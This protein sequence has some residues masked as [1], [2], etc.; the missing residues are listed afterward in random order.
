MCHKIHILVICLALFLTTNSLSLNNPTHDAASISPI[1]LYPNASNQASAPVNPAPAIPTSI[2]TVQPVSPIANNQP[3]AP[4][5]TGSVAPSSASIAPSFFYPQAASAPVNNAQLNSHPSV[6]A[7]AQQ[8]PVNPPSVAPQA[9]AS[10]LPSFFYPNVS[11]PQ[12]QPAPQIPVAQPQVPVAQPQAPATVP[13]VPI[14]AQPSAP[15][16]PPPAQPAPQAPVVPAF[17]PSSFV[18]A[19]PLVNC[20]NGTVQSPVNGSCVCPASAPHKNSTGHCVACPAG[21][22]FNSTNKTCECNSSSLHKLNNG[23]C[24]ACHGNSTFNSTLQ[25][26]GCSNVSYQMDTKGQCIYCPHPYFL[27]HNTS[28][29]VKCPTGFIYYPQF[30]ACA[31]PQTKPFLLANLTCIA[32]NTFFNTTNKTCVQCTANQ[33]WNASAKA[34][35]CNASYFSNSSG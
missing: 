23:S 26:C 14:G 30:G 34:C 4:V 8:A 13:S 27:D 5:N 7:P 25:A 19:I 33:T 28:V 12:T 1:F 15:I 24:I 10:I 11:A 20:V 29:C 31:C 18:N 3:A 21:Q 17:I 2:P 22:I 16:N 32:C 6:V 35:Q 9:P